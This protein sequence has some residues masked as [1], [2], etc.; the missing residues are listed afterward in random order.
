MIGKST[1]HHG[2]TCRECDW[3]FSVANVYLCRFAWFAGV[4]ISEVLPQSNACPN[5]RNAEE[6]IARNGRGQ[7]TE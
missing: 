1:Q 3:S 4:Q 7:E 2:K 6:D 5:Y